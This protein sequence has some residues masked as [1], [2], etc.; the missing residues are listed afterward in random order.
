MNTDGLGN[1][2][3]WMLVTYPAVV[4]YFCYAQGSRISWY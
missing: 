1:V 3:L 2:V 4:A